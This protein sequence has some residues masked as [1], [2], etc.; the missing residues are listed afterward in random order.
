M[1]C[2]YKKALN[3]P[4][5][6]SSTNSYF[7][8]CKHWLFEMFLPKTFRNLPILRKVQID[9]NRVEVGFFLEK[10]VQVILSFTLASLINLPPARLTFSILGFRSIA[11]PSNFFWFWLHIFL[12][13]NRNVGRRYFVEG[14]C[15]HCFFAHF[16]LKLF[17]WKIIDW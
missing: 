16:N 11:A 17:C 8:R 5:F 3:I 14:A 13:N 1:D 4:C 10:T 12:F 9:S 7:C 6:S 15:T 2:F